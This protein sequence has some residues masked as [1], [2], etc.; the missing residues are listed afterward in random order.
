MFIPYG[1]QSINEEDIAAVTEALKGDLITRGPKVEAFEK[2]IAS[3]CGAEYAVAFTSGTT[4]LYASYFAIDC[5]PKDRVLTSPNTFIATTAYPSQK[6]ATVVFVDIDRSSGN[7]DLEQVEANLHYPSIQG[8]LIIAPV[9]FSGIAIDMQR[10]QTMIK[11]S[12]VAIIE[13]AAHALG[14]SYP[15]GE[16][17]GSCAYSDLTIFSFH[18]VK[19]LT[20]GEGGMVTTNDPELYQRLKLFRNSGIVRDFPDPFPDP[21]YYEVQELAGQYHMTEF[22]AALGLSQFKRLDAFIE[23]RRALVKRYRERL[24]GVSSIRLFDSSYDPLTAY[25]LMVVQMTSKKSRTAIMDGLNKAGIGSQLHYIPLYRHPCYRRLM[26]DI[27]EYFPEM[28]AYYSSA[29]SLP[30]YYDLTLEDV[31]RISETLLKQSH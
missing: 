19:T 18:P 20:T 16:K 7:M 13:D 31:D 21:W 5:G 24:S 17:V 26:G 15:S 23:K 10:L 27:E 9:H 2:Q 4:A 12:N 25:H 1:H 22:Q 3:Y 28:E 30:L 11:A 14:S 8:R 29:L 6:G